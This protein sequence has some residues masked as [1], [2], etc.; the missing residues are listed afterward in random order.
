MCRQI[1]REFCSDDMPIL[2]VPGDYPQVLEPGEK[3]KPGYTEGGV[4]ETTMGA[5]LP[6]SFGPGLPST[7]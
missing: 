7:S 3:R 6:E 5:L 4:K 1:L 2:L